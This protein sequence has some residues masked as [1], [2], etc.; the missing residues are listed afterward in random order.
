[1]PT[2]RQLRYLDALAAN[3]HFG[4]A[5]AAMG[6]S[7]PA[8]SMQIR[9]LE[10]ELGAAVVERLPA[11]ARLT[12]LGT[13]VVARATRILLSEYIKLLRSVTHYGLSRLWPWGRSIPLAHGERAA[14]K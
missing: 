3:G 4:R 12:P 8:L 11:G 14:G 5:A 2:L 10:T 7:Q 1:M 13:E 6:V 9:E